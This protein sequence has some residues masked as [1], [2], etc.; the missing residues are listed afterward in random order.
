MAS[1]DLVGGW[2]FFRSYQF[3][4]CADNYDAWE[5]CN[6]EFGDATGGRDGE[7]GGIEEGA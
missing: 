4:A 2:G 1:A 3:I 5:C 6:T 7:F